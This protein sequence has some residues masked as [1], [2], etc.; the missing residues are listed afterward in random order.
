MVFLV[1]ASQSPFGW[2]P[3]ENGSAKYITTRTG[4]RLR[5]GLIGNWKSAKSHIPRSGLRGSLQDFTCPSTAFIR[6]VDYFR[7][8][9]HTGYS[10]TH[11]RIGSGPYS[12]PFPFPSGRHT[13]QREYRTMKSEKPANGKGRTGNGRLEQNYHVALS[14]AGED[15]EYVK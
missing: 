2:A 3:N 12:Y 10:K 1:A 8:D 7:V 13:L 15:R 5:N 6:H 14:F 4:F 9:C 11:E